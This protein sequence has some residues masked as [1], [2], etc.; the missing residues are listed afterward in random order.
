MSQEQPT[1]EPRLPRQWSTNR[2]QRIAA[3]IRNTFGGVLF[4]EDKA[5]SIAILPVAAR[6]VA[7]K[8]AIIADLKHIGRRAQAL[9][10]RYKRSGGASSAWTSS[11]RC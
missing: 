6:D 4:A 11:R 8:K 5:E 7:K 10:R 1:F 3:G 9:E 2:Q